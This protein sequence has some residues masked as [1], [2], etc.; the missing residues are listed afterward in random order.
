MNVTRG[1]EDV[2]GVVPHARDAELA[3]GAGCLRVVGMRMRAVMKYHPPAHGCTGQRAIVGIQHEE[4][5][6]DRV[7]SRELRTR[8][9]GENDDLRREILERDI[10]G[11]AEQRPREQRDDPGDA[12]D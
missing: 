1:L 11:T 7:P 4:V 8:G 10:V 9:W 6:R 5:D 2:G 3:G 12:G